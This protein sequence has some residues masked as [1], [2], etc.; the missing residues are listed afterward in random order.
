MQS[1]VCQDDFKGSRHRMHQ[2][3]LGTSRSTLPRVV[4]LPS[5]QFPHVCG[6]IRHDR[7]PRR[8][9]CPEQN[10]N[11]GLLQHIRLIE[12]FAASYFSCSV[13]LVHRT[14]TLLLREW[15]AATIIILDCP[16]ADEMASIRL[17][18]V[19]GEFVTSWLHSR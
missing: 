14:H 3:P 12:P 9:T 8:S 11:V 18:L 15:Q 2:P 17:V 13:A 10:L 7:I 1:C 4:S 16:L 5:S 6:S 19:G